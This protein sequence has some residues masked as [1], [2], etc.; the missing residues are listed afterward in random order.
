MNNRPHIANAG[1]KLWAIKLIHTVI[2]AFFVFVIFYILYTG[3]ADTVNIYTWIGIVLILG[4]GLTLLIFK[5]FCPLTLIARKYSDST[6]D[7]FDIFL[8]NWLARHNKL[9]FT[10]I[11]AIGVLIVIYRTIE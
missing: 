2:W 8:P 5:M 3:I 10:S 6:K 9:I 4:E 1:K 11:F 7:N